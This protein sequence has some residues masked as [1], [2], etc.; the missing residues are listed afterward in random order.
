[1]K[2]PGPGIA[3]LFVM[4]LGFLI[5][6]TAMYLWNTATDIFMPVNTNSQANMSLEI[7]PGE[8]TA[9]IA[10][11]L[12]NKGLI[13]NVLAFRIW[14]RIKGLDTKLQAGLYKGLSPKMSINDIAEQL[15]NG[16]PDAI[17]VLI[18]EGYRL[19]Q[20]ANAFDQATPKLVNFKKSEF[21][22][23]VRNI[24]DF[25]DKGNYPI[26]QDVPSGDT[27]E[28]LLFPSTYEVPVGST[29]R[30][31]VNQLLK[32]MQ[33]VI[34]QNHLDTIAQQHQYQNVYQLITLASIVERETSKATN[35]ENIASVYWNRLFK[36]NT[37]TAGLL[38]ADPT[39]Q[40]ARDSV[41][42]PQKY[43]EP[44]NDDPKNIATDSPWNTYLN[45]GLP[46]TPIC[47]PGLASLTTTANPPSTDYLYFFASK[48]GNTY[49]AKT[50]AEFE[51][52][53][54]EHAINT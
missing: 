21:L 18:P 45:K 39:V 16:Q 19:E 37:E 3:I 5:F 12:Q 50:N 4:L 47:S 48:D 31:V 38:Q 30:D 52:L 7:K 44:L 54:S 46:P 27:M 1:M 26:L 34:Q 13:R 8:N 53:K 17:P 41:N 49:F 29:A 28:G 51:L 35:R 2:R 43:W 42:P 15:L 36:P 33:D 9:D 6:G 23:Y 24:Q 11:D 22:D 14:A 10:D 32:Q 25:P 40:Y 20:I